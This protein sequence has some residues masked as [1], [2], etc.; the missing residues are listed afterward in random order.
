MV[1][2]LGQWLT[3]ATWPTSQLAPLHYTIYFGLDLTGPTWQLYALPGI[4]TL[5]ILFHGLVSFSQLAALWRRM[6]SFTALVNLLLLTAAMVTLRFI[7][8]R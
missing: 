4:G 2:N 1:L 7:S 6:W 5:I 8:I 3:I